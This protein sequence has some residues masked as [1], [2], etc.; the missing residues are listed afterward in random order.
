MSGGEGEMSSGFSFG[1]SFGDDAG[2][3]G[4]AS[5]PAGRPSGAS[6]GKVE[7]LSGQ[8]EKLLMITEALWTMLKEE[9]GY[10]DEDLIKKIME[11]DM[12]DGRLDGRVAKS[13]PVVCPKCGRPAS[14]T[15]S[16]CMY[17]GGLI[18]RTPFER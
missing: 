11:I 9:H 12:R 6:E 2:M 14:R 4:K 18:V 16:L 10:V 17:C 3:R 5:E 15:R 7:E 8:V 1:F 13:E